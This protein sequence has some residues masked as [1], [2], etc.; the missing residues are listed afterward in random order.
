MRKILRGLSIAGTLAVGLASA[1]GLPQPA[2]ADVPE[3][4]DPI[5]IALFDWT[6]VNVNA[7]ILG[8]ILHRRLTVFLLSA[9]NHQ[10]E[11]RHHE[12]AND[13]GVEQDAESEGEADL[14]QRAQAA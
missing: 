14:N 11:R 7:K 8:G 12:R 5:K 2:R 1:I 4:Q 9:P 13:E 3:S 6:S 10:R